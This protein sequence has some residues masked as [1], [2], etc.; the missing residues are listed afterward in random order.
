ME[1]HFFMRLLTSKL[2]QLIPGLLLLA[3][4]L[5]MLFVV[6]SP[7]LLH[8]YVVPFGDDPVRHITNAIEFQETGK[9]LPKEG[10]LDPPFVRIL[11]GSFASLLG[12]E[13]HSFVTYFVPFILI[14]IVFSSYVVARQ[15]FKSEKAA[16]LSVVFFAFLTP[17]PYSI[18][19]EGTFM[20]L[21]A[22]L[23]IFP[24]A[25]TFFI[26]MFREKKLSQN[27]FAAVVL[28]VG[29]MGYHSLTSVYFFLFLVFSC[30]YLLLQLE[31]G[32]L[33]RYIQYVIPVGI[34]GGLVAFE[35]FVGRSLFFVLEKIGLVE[36]SADEVLG[37]ISQDPAGTLAHLGT[38]MHVFGYFVFIFGFLGLVW[39]LARYEKTSRFERVLFV[40]WPVS[41]FVGSQI[42][43]LPLSQRFAR[44]V[45]YSFAVLSALFFVAYVFQQSYL[46]KSLA[47]GFVLLL[48]CVSGLT[49]V[50]SRRRFNG[51]M[52]VLPVD[53]RAYEWTKKNLPA[54]S[55]I[56]ASSGVVNGGWG[57]Y[58]RILTG[59]NYIDAGICEDELR[60]GYSQCKTLY[61]PGSD[62][63]R[64]FYKKQGIDYVYSNRNILPQQGVLYQKID[65]SYRNE[66]EKMDYLTRVASFSDQNIG[67]VIIYEVNKDAL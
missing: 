11:F 49:L 40:I 6:Y 44:D 31:W 3:V 2:Y 39:F 4:F 41:L 67:D 60:I 25:I 48:V 61:E 55:T 1:T 50:E 65:Y 56:L 53:L 17:Q 33:K 18:Y 36:A 51:M 20:N 30:V 8:E 21:F 66:L 35:Y 16:V 64:S 28:G 46:K 59:L 47:I 45:V 7:L 13:V 57:S 14:L 12:V 24:L 38:F 19:D 15:I 37:G 63:A 32:Y 10:E 62:A 34:F 52:R 5:V 23:L 29:V 27:Y 43:F 26:Q 9:L 22:A 58:A 42:E 54:E